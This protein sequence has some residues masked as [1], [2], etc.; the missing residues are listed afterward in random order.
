MLRLRRDDVAFLLLVEI[1]DTLDGDVV[2]LGGAG[3]K[4]YF[5]GGSADEGRN[6]SAGVLNGVVGFPT[7]EVGAR[8]RVPIAREIEGEHGVEDPRVHR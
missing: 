4:D 6:L 3:G 5:F 2:G 7:I 1:H 8:V